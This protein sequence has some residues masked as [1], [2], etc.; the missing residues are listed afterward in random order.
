MTLAF[1]RG[2]PD[3]YDVIHD[4]ETVGRIYRM[5]GDRELWRWKGC[6]LR[7]P[8]R[9]AGICHPRRGDGS[10]SREVG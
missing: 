8:V 9:A 6:G 10:L 2:G 3:D 1:H 4:G 5:K 7:L